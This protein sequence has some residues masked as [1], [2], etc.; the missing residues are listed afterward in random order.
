MPRPRWTAVGVTAS[1]GPPRP[2]GLASGWQVQGR[3]GVATGLCSPARVGGPAEEVDSI[4]KKHKE[5]SSP[6]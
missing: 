1:S 4:L 6:D 2:P 5:S 3:S